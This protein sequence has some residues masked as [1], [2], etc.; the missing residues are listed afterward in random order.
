MGP[1]VGFEPTAYRLQ[2]GCATGLRHAGRT[3]AAKPRA[4]KRVDL[5]PMG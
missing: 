1:A 5:L 3:Y 4:A 2:V